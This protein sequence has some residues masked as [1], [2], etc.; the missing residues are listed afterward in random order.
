VRT[1]VQV[2]L[3]RDELAALLWE[4]FHCGE[5]HKVRP[6]SFP[7]LVGRPEEHASIDSATLLF[8]GAPPKERE[9]FTRVARAIIGKGRRA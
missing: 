4:F 6:P 8:R 7:N 2:T 5:K 3:G 1:P 9:A